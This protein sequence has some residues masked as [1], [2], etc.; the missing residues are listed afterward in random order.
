ME[1]GETSVFFF[2]EVDIF[3]KEN[4]CICHVMQDGTLA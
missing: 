2:R 1:K 4:C 3:F